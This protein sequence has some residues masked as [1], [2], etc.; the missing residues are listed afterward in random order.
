MLIIPKSSDEKERLEALNSYQILD[1][2]PK[3][4]F[5]RFTKLA[6]IICEV[7]ISLV[8]LIDENRQWFKSKLG[9]DIDETSRDIAF[10]SHAILESGIMEVED[11]SQDAR[12]KDNPLVTAAP[13]IKFYAGCPL[14]D[15]NG[16][17]LGTLCVVDRKPKKLRPDQKM[18]LE[19]LAQSVIDLIVQQRKVQEVE[20]F[21]RL[22]RISKDLICILEP[23]GNFVNVNPGF[24]Y[25][26]DWDTPS[27]IKQSFFDFVHPDDLLATKEKIDKLAA[28]AS[29]VSFSHR[30]RAKDGT[31]KILEWAATPEPSSKMYFAIARDV[32]DA[33]EKEIALQRSELR[34]RAFFENSTGFMCT[35]DLDGRFLTINSSGTESLGYST[36]ELIGKTLFDI[37]PE[38]RYEYVR[39]YLEAIKTDGKADG[40]MRTRGRSGKTLTWLFNNVLET[41]PN[42]EKYIIGNAVDITERYRLEADLKRTKEMMEQTNGVA[43][44]GAW[45]VNLKTG[46]IYWSKVT[47]ILHE[48]DENYEPSLE[49]A[50]SF[51][52]NVDIVEEAFNKAIAQGV[53]Y[54]M[55]LQVTTAKGKKMW[56]RTIGTPEFKDGNCVRIFGTFQDI[57]ENYLHRK[58]LKT[59][60]IQAEEASV[61]KSEF[62]ASMSHEI[63]TPLNGVIG[64]TDLV[65][66]TSLNQ[67][68]QQYLT[69]VNQSANSLLT[70]IND[71]LDF[72]K[73]EAG[74]LELDIE[75]SDLFELTSQ[76]SDIITFQAQNKG[77]EVLLN[78][79]PNLPRFVF[80]DNTRLKQVLVNLLGNAVKFTEQGEIELKI[81]A[82]SDLRHEYV[83]FHFEVR[84]TGIGIQPDKQQKIFEA[85]SQED[86]STTKKYGGTGLGLTISNR[87]LGLMGSQLQLKS[88]VGFGSSFYFKLRLKAEHGEANLSDDISFVKNVLVVDDNQNNRLILKQMLL[89]KDIQVTEAKNGLEALQ[90][91]SEGKRYD[92][93]LMDYHMPY[94]DGLET[95]EKIRKSFEQHPEDQ[96][97]ML[98]HSS[99]DDDKIIQVCEEHGV[100]LRMVKPIKMQDL[101]S[102][103]AKLNHKHE[104]GT[105]AVEEEKLQDDSSFVILVAEDNLVNKLLAKTVIAR[106][107][108]NANIIEANDGTE[109][110]EQYQ[111][112]HPDLVLMDLQMPVM[113]GWEATEKIRELQADGNPA[114]TIV[115]LT[116]GNV[117][118]EREKCLEIGMDDFLTKPF[119]EEDLASLFSRW[120][121]KDTPTEIGEIENPKQHAHFNVDTLKQFMGQ[122][123]ET[124]K[125]VLNL[126]I[127]E[128]RKVDANLKEFVASP[129]LNEINALGHKLYGT[130]S[131]TG[132]EVLANMARKLEQLETV[133]NLQLKS[134]YLALHDEVELVID[135]IN[136]ELES[137]V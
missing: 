85:F 104:S 56:V 80:I 103:L 4:A 57:T 92:V 59:A 12:F 72:S 97:I 24:T 101:F 126:T 121:K 137:F 7:P 32:T 117:K 47:R 129:D 68:Q 25:L 118:G 53:S 37:V 90:L 42:G 69:I 38:D 31:Y 100:V 113:N 20:N 127:D 14:V 49:R 84:D 131:G 18:A 1:T 74:K 75:K 29:T 114:T 9:I 108:P 17:A 64:F 19:L 124:V 93:I 67:T 115:A 48:V 58:A 86:A 27:L 40:L 94:M 26:L 87:L 79:D 136:K 28:G 36:E 60:K 76:S 23:S 102:K 78:I 11:A 39:M 116:A 44:I 105:V 88:K 3:E 35:H 2:L 50:L 81:Y 46:K 13:N 110:V 33:R 70:I 89:L 63:R 134:L 77:L 106:I 10:C 30:F 135:R 82:E 107:L 123:V 125:L 83:D 132:L 21:D 66:K 61:A 111:L 43:R 120:L 51:F 73:I 15:P 91:L 109:A 62:L 122:D 98:L 16:F 22:F 119:V 71:I 99:S 8:S 54:D 133:E 6:S 45:E 96:P 34:L 128:L 5:D 130:A 52:D 112:H 95:I 55:E 65:L 41:D